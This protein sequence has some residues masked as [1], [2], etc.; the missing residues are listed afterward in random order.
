[1]EA[2]AREPR[3]QGVSK[4]PPLVWL[5]VI[6]LVIEHVLLE[7]RVAHVTLLGAGDGIEDLGPVQAEH[8]LTSRAGQPVLDGLVLFPI[9]HDLRGDAALFQQLCIFIF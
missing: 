7:D 3:R 9:A 5:A 2:K 8:F 1:M 4:F 6:V